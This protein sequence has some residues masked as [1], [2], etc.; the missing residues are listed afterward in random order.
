MAEANAPAKA[1]CPRCKGVMTLRSRRRSNKPDDVV[2]FWRHDDHTNP[3][4]P[5]RFR[6][7]MID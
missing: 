6:Y 1:L 7:Y 2:Y 5:A 3:S 4:C